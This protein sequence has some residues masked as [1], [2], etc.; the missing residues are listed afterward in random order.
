[1]AEEISSLRK[2]LDQSLR[3]LGLQKR[4]KTEQLSVLWPKIVGPSVAKIAFPAQLRNGTLFID[5]ADNVWMQELKFQEGELI[6]RLNEALHEP[7]VR[8]LFFQLARTPLP[9]SN[10]QRES[11]SV[12]SAATPLDPQQELALERDV[13]SVRD[14]ELRGV[15]KDFRR[16]LLQARP[17]P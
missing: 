6:G 13:A 4:L 17:T 14:P 8:R 7:L 1:V 9:D 5:V 16:R 3:D 10:S 15:L 12:P 11:P 2:A